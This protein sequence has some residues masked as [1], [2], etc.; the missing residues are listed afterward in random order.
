TPGYEQRFF[1]GEEL[2]GKLRLIAS[3]DGKD[4]AV[5]IN[6]DASVY[7]ALLNADQSID[8]PLDADRYAWLQLARGG[9]EVNGAHLRAGDGAAIKKESRVTISAAENSEF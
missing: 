3:R 5:T 1:V 9:L 6:Q 4:G 8:H 2:T 7:A